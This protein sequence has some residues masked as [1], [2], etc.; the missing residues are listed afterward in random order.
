M[1]CKYNKETK[2]CEKSID[3]DTCETSYLNLYGCVNI[4][5]VACKWSD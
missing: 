4:L 3:S 5:N 1:K 2:L